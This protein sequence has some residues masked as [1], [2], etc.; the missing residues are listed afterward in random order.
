MVMNVCRRV[1]GNHHAAEEAWQSTFLVLARRAGSVRPAAALAAWLHGVARRVALKARSLATRSARESVQ[2]LAHDPLDPHPDPLAEVSVREL[3]TL[4]D[5]EVSRLPEVYRLPV[6]LCCFEGHT[7]EEAARQLGWSPGSLQGR[8]ERGRK[9]LHER[10]ARRGLTLAAALAAL[11]ASRALA[12]PIPAALTSSAVEAAVFISAGQPLAE[13]VVS[14]SVLALT[15]G[16]L[17]TM[18]LMHLKTLM[19]ALLLAAALLAGGTALLPRQTAAARQADD[20]PFRPVRPSAV[21][22]DPPKSTITWSEKRVIEPHGP[23]GDQIFC[24]AFSPNG[25]LI[26]CGLSHNGKLLDAATGEEKA[27]LDVNHP[28]CCAFSPDGKTLAT[29]HLDSLLLWDVE[30]GKLL[31]T[32]DDKTKNMGSVAFSRDGKVLLSAE[33]DKVRLW[34]VAARKETRRFNAGDPEKR[35]VYAAAFS[36][37]EKQIATAEGPDKRVIVWEV[38]SGKQIRILAGFTEYAVAVAWS[39]DGRTLAV[40]DGAGIVRLFD[41]KSGKLGANLKGPINGGGSLVFSPDGKLLASGGGGENPSVRLWDVASRKE[42]AT[43]KTHTKQVWSAAFSHD[44]K[45]LVTAGDDAVRVWEA[46]R[47]PAK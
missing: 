23:R 42:V 21:R 10:M 19:A 29:G 46:Q 8:L 36:P 26:F 45:R 33:P 43:L 5:E 2:P 39:P 34:D 16:V 22:A 14:A 9:K 20:R 1:L 17:K 41:P 18:F 35:V 47:R 27:V 28:R 32:L 31:A 37:D 38:A 7:Q 40:S 3:L 24:A 15:R 44:G 12:A 30:T 6:L 4:I 11:E 25:K 13:G